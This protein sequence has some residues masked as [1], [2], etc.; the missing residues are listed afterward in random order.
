M[1]QSEF[2]SLRGYL[3]SVEM[4]LLSGEVNEKEMKRVMRDINISVMNQRGVNFGVKEMV[5]IFIT[6]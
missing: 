5:N 3:A 4:D 2:D 1:F 6:V